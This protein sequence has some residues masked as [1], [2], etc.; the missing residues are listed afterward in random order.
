M[1]NLYE[2]QGT[3]GRSKNPTT[4]FVYEKRN[5]AKWYCA[6]NSQGVNCTYQ[7][8][9]EGCDIEELQ[10]FDTITST[11]PLDTLE[12]FYNFIID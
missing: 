6:E 8:I 2:I 12:D 5:G 11:K 9:K 7:D 10:D 4:I 3:Y 1:S